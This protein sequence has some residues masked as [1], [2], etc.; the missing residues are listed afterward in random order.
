MSRKWL[1][2]ALGAA[3]GMFRR[4]W[5]VVQQ[6]RLTGRTVVV[7]RYWLEINAYLA[8]D[9]LTEQQ[10]DDQLSAL[11]DR[12]THGRPADPDAQQFIW[13]ARKETR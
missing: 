7:A 3:A 4:P 9:R 1:S 11:I 12:A 8:V 13:Y 10:R 5:A 2:V 6:E